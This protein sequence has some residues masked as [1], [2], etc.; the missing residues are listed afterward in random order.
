[1]FYFCF[2]EAVIHVL[3]SN[4]K[5]E[6]DSNAIYPIKSSRKFHNDFTYWPYKDVMFDQPTS[7]LYDEEYIWKVYSRSAGQKT[8]CF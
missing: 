3:I 5:T 4:T 2:Q 8:P 7:Q 6:S 1:M